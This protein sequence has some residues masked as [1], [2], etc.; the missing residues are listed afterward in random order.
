MII[1]LIGV[2]TKLK[3]K[4]EVRSISRLSIDLLRDIYINYLPPITN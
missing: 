1:F 3:T 4:R 2:V